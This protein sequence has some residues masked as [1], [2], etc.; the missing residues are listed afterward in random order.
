MKTEIPNPGDVYVVP[1]PYMRDEEAIE[2]NKQLAENVV[3]LADMLRD[4]PGWPFQVADREAIECHAAWEW[5]PGMRSEYHQIDIDY[6]ERTWRSDGL[7]RT[8]ISVVSVHKPSPRH[9]YRVFYYQRWLSPDGRVEGKRAL[10]MKTLR[11]FR[12]I[13]KGITPDDF[14]VEVDEYAVSEAFGTRVI[15]CGKCGRPKQAKGEEDGWTC[16]ICSM[17]K[18]WKRPTEAAGSALEGEG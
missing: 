10:K 15:E 17:G 9:D 2:G 4:D 3:E 12:T 14:E 8:E 7:G 16:G 18:R 1:W 5:K 6:G 13:A 11:R